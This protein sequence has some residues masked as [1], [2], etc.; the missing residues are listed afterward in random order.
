MVHAIFAVALSDISLAFDN[1]LANSQM[2]NGLPRHQQKKALVFGMILSCLTMIL[3]T[4]G[5]V[6]LRKHLDFIRYPAALWL[7]YV[8]WSLWFGKEK[9]AKPAQVSRALMKAVLLI[10]FTD[11][12]MAA[13]NAIANSEFAM[14]VHPDHVWTVLIFGLLLS[15]AFMIACTYAIMWVRRI[16]EWIK[17]PAGLWLLAVAILMLT[18]KGH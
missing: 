17:Y 18:G 11:I 10:A 9:E 4:L 3:L 8:V 2:A 5:V 12:T 7:L 1:A 6:Y 15:C 16:A 14:R 13:D